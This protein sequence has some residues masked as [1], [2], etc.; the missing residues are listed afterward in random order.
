MNS[1]LFQRYG[2]PTYHLAYCNLQIG[3]KS[4]F[5]FLELEITVASVFVSSG[6]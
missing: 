5:L 2:L 4:S 3:N 6:F 1:Q